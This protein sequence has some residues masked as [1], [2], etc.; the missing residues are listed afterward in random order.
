MTQATNCG[1]A[2]S[3][4]QNLY[5]MATVS[6]GNEPVGY[7]L[8]LHRTCTAACSSELCQFT[9][10]HSHSNGQS[11][12]VISTPDRKGATVHKVLLFCYVLA[13]VFLVIVL[14]IMPPSYL[15]LVFVRFAAVG[16]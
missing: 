5:P 7:A 2:T 6:R 13:V 1:P 12:A 8:L 9:E 15:L 4:T 3:F 14:T 10:P 11:A 16:G